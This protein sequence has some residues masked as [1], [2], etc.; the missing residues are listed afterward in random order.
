MHLYSFLVPSH[1]N[2]IGFHFDISA[3]HSS[4]P[5]LR[6]TTRPNFSA[7]YVAKRCLHMKFDSAD[8]TDSVKAGQS[9]KYLFA[10]GS[11]QAG[12]L[13]NT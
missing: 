1:L 2:G 13:G 10:S 7:R 12:R 8:K 6:S 4:N 11:V 3:V 9:Q 5:S